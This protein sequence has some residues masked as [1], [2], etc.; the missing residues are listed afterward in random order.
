MN[1]RKIDIELSISN[2]NPEEAK[3]IH[4]TLNP[5][6]LASPPMSISS[7]WEESM[8]QISIKDVQNIDTALATVNDLLEAY[9]LSKDILGILK[10]DI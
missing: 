1:V 7:K 6:N 3:I 2:D 8:L 10:P 4:K 5:D 9:R